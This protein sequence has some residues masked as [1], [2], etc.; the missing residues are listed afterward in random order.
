M[1]AAVVTAMSSGFDDACP[2][3]IPSWS[4]NPYPKP[5]RIKYP[6][7]L[8]EAVSIPNV[9]TRPLPIQ[10]RTAP[11]SMM[12]IGIPIAVMNAAAL[13]EV[14]VMAMMSGSIRIPDE[15]GL[16]PR[17]DWKYRGRRYIWR[18]NAPPIL[19]IS[20]SDKKVVT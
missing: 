1:T 7:Q 11:M 4:V 8:L 16:A 20:T 10:A 9:E 6:I 12:Y 19:I 18:M 5:R 15:I 17:I 13:M 3:M 14:I 2:T